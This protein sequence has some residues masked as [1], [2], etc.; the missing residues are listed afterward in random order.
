MPV[1]AEAPPAVA[2]AACAEQIENIGF[3]TISEL[4]ERGTAALEAR[5]DYELAERGL[6]GNPQI[7]WARQEIRVLHE[8]QKRTNGPFI[9]HVLRST[10]WVVWGLECSGPDSIVAALMHDSVEDQAQLI[11]ERHGGGQVVDDL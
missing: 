6:A 9:D 7:A 11:V 2:N 10:L 5:L 4:S 8:K 1:V 3:M